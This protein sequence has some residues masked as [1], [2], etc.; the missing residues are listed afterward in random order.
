M[1]KFSQLWMFCKLHGIL[2]KR[3][4][5]KY[6]L[7]MQIKSLYIGHQ[8]IHQ[9]PQGMLKRSTTLHLTSLISFKMLKKYFRTQR[10]K[11]T[12]AT[13]TMICPTY[14]KDYEFL[15]MIDSAT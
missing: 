8:S 2:D 5:E 13:L 6:N 11:S 10:V 3:N 1:H 7:P 4:E 9:V 14:F 12:I 15:F